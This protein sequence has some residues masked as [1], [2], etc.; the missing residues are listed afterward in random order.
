M[1]VIAITALEQGLWLLLSAVLP[2]LL[3]AALAEIA[4]GLLLAR[5][6]VRASSSSMA[7][8]RLVSVLFALALCAPWIAEE[9]LRFT[10]TLLL[11][12]PHVSH[13]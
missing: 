3:A 1:T 8:V 12:L 11:L 6:Q 2:P 7:L 4:L 9:L 13:L 5:F 10:R